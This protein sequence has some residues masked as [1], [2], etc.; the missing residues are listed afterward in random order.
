MRQLGKTPVA[1][2]EEAGISGNTKNQS[3]CAEKANR[4]MLGFLLEIQPQY[5][6]H[7]KEGTLATSLTDLFFD[8]AQQAASLKEQVLEAGPTIAK[9]I[10]EEL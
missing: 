10:K 6:C 9:E 8:Y 1:N 5:G 4:A 2:Y 3:H 7:D